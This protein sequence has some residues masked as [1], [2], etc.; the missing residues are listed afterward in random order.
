METREFWV[1]FEFSGGINDYSVVFVVEVTAE[2][3]FS[4]SIGCDGGI[5]NVGKFIVIAILIKLIGI[6]GVFN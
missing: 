6:C 1:A 4:T 2:K 3:Q 5:D